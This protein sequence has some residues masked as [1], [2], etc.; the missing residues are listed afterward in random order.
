[1]HTY[2]HFLNHQNFAF[3]SIW[4]FVFTGFINHKTYL[5]GQLTPLGFACLQT[6]RIDQ[7]SL[8]FLLV[9]NRYVKRAA[10]LIHRENSDIFLNKC[11]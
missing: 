6:D 1:M 2:V 4:M 5:L 8:G 10:I 9:L 3:I 7:K 11:I